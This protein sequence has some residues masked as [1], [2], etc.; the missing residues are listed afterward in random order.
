ME[1]IVPEVK[2]VLDA[3]F[4]PAALAWRAFANRIAGQSLPIRI[5][6]EQGNGSTYVFERAIDRDT[7]SAATA[8]NLR[9]L[10]R[11]L[12]FLLWA[13]GGCRIHLD[14]PELLVGLLRDYIYRYSPNR[15]FDV[16]IMGPLIYGKPFEILHASGSAFPRPRMSRCLS[17]ATKAAA[18]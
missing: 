9:F 2:P 12:K 7:S 15:L 16:D 17:A 14:A 8:V 13:V 10:E 6:V 18:A 3:E 1:L 5:A 4:R 11:E